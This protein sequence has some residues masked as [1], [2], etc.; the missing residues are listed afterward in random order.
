MT[1]RAF[2]FTTSEVQGAVFGSY[3]QLE[4]IDYRF[5]GRERKRTS[6]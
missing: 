1:P 2:R 3:L 5:M 4:M 6:G